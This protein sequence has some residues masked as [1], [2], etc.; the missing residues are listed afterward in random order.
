MSNEHKEFLVDLLSKYLEMK[1]V[2]EFNEIGI[3]NS[4]EKTTNYT[5]PEYIHNS[6]FNLFF[7]ISNP[8]QQA[9]SNNKN[10]NLT[11]KKDINNKN[12]QKPNYKINNV[13]GIKNK[14]NNFFYQNNDIDI[15]NNNDDDNIIESNGID[16]DDIDVFNDKTLK[17][18][19]SNVLN[20]KNKLDDLMKKNTELLEQN[21][22]L[23][24]KIN[25]LDKELNKKQKF[26][27]TLKKQKNELISKNTETNKKKDIEKENMKN[28]MNDY[29]LLKK[30]NEKTNMKLIEYETLISNYKKEIE[31]LKNNLN[32]KENIY[33]SMK[34]D[35]EEKLSTKE[36]KIL[37]LEKTKDQN[38]NL[39]KENQDLIDSNN[40]LQ[41]Y[42]EYK[43]KYENL[44]QNFAKISDNSNDKLGSEMNTIEEKLLISLKNNLNIQKEN[45]KLRN[46]IHNWKNELLRGQSYDESNHIKKQTRQSQ[47]IDY[48]NNL[49]EKNNNIENNKN[50]KNIKNNQQKSL[51]EGISNQNL[52]SDNNCIRYSEPNVILGNNFENLNDK[53]TLSLNPNIISSTTRKIK[54]IND[55][56]FDSSSGR[57]GHLYSN[58]LDKNVLK[59]AKTDAENNDNNKQKL[60]KTNI[61][62]KYGKNFGSNCPSLNSSSKINIKITKNI[63]NKLNEDSRENNIID[64]NKIYDQLYLWLKNNKQNYPEFLNFAKK[65]EMNYKK[66]NSSKNNS[67]RNFDTNNAII[68]YK[69]NQ[70][71]LLQNQLN[72]ARRKESEA[73][74]KLTFMESEKIK[75]AE[76]K[77]K[78]KENLRKLEAKKSI[79]E[80]DFYSNSDRK[81]KK[82]FGK[83]SNKSILTGFPK[84]NLNNS[85]KNN[86]K[87][88]NHSHSQY[89]EKNSKYSF[90]R[91]KGYFLKSDESVK[92]N[93]FILYK[94]L[95][96]INSDEMKN[97]TK[98]N[99][100]DSRKGENNFESNNNINI[101]GDV[102]DD[103]SERKEENWKIEG[104]E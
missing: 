52:L 23:T 100:N 38:L 36:A 37:D 30:E 44:L 7:E 48:I 6:Q 24:K 11:F 15:D 64:I 57:K 63:E 86:A 49:M 92:Q 18:N 47:I 84:I 26:I 56:S 62:Y 21:Q 75:I 74:L 45:V 32:E 98:I 50:K 5:M 19:S 17:I 77:N 59:Y 67:R 87:I 102:N 40:K 16:D 12:L 14:N 81:E 71:K 96:E 79:S 42:K 35:L 93:S 90:R 103:N 3:S 94:K 60:I 31:N 66:N 89:P 9:Y 76:E 29:E 13:N 82:R 34:K 85:S 99:F 27:N 80:F 95:D 4:H 58:L 68:D 46:E 91:K 25:F 8:T 101:S 65:I 88:L 1:R 69:D 70:I 72:N 53:K 39:S 28:I 43:E 22:N 55:Q 41:K 83:S 10:K 20:D 104:N 73:K 54:K 2:F 51:T 33:N 61:K 97:I 78:L